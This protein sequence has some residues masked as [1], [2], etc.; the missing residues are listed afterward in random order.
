MLTLQLFGGCTLA[1]NGEAITGPAVQRRRLA[2]LALLAVS[3]GQSLS[4]DK[5]VAY[6]WP[7]EERDRARHFLSDSLFRLRKALGR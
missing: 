4:R 1:S 5:L 3:P 2:L 6:F 7:E